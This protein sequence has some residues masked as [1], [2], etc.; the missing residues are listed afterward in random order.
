MYDMQGVIGGQMPQGEMMPGAAPSPGSPT[1]SAPAA[2]P[3]KYG[4]DICVMGLEQL[5]AQARRLGDEALSTETAQMGLKL[6]RRQ[7]KRQNVADA[8]IEQGQAQVIM[9]QM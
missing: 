2:D 8:A 1:G 4:I 7:Q 3:L 5:S 9:G 6:R